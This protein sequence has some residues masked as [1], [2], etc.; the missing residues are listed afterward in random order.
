MKI[1]FT[2]ESALS[3]L[4]PCAE[5]VVKN[6]P[7][8]AVAGVL[9]QASKGRALA[10]TTN[11]EFFVEAEFSAEVVDGKDGAVVVPF[12]AFT[13]LIRSLPKETKISLESI[14]G[15][16]KLEFRAGGNSTVFS[17]FP[18]GDFPLPPGK[19]AAALFEVDAAVL[20]SALRRVKH[21]ASEDLSRPVFS[22]VWVQGDEEGVY[23]ACSDTYRVAAEKLPCTSSGSFTVLVPLKAVDPLFHVQ[24]SDGAAASFRGGQNSTASFEL[25][26]LRV[27]TRTV[28]GVL[29]A[30]RDFF[31]EKEE[32]EAWASLS[33]EEL[34][35]A[36]ERVALFAEDADAR[37]VF[38]EVLPDRVVL[39]SE[40]Q[41]GRAEETVPANAKGSVALYFNSSY[42]LEALRSVKRGVVTIAFTSGDHLRA[43]LEFDAIPGYRVLVMGVLR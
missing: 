26:S 5:A 3:A 23:V 34:V 40:S 39:K 12:T 22:S 31:F 41:L 2:R 21:A 11:L 27:I 13:S 20:V 8:P 29:P 10:S 19:P 16:E 9:V 28:E 35:G 6:T 37:A 18:L 32:A 17:G 38:F 30:W 14:D 4:T 42:M 1:T 15:E 7:I 24:V 25:P 36:L 33:C 43:V